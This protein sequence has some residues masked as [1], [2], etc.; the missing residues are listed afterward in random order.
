MKK[1]YA[2][3]VLILLVV[4]TVSGQERLHNKERSMSRGDVTDDLEEL[5]GKPIHVL[6]INKQTFDG[7]NI[8]K[9]YVANYRIYNVNDTAKIQFA[10]KH[11]SKE[12]VDAACTIV[13]VWKNNIGK[14]HKE[15]VGLL[16][17][18]KNAQY[19]AIEI[20]LWI[21]NPTQYGSAI[22]KWEYL[23]NPL[24]EYIDL[25][26]YNSIMESYK[27]SIV[28][29]MAYYGTFVDKVPQESKFEGAFYDQGWKRMILRFNKDSKSYEV[30][31]GHSDSD[32]NNYYKISQF[33]NDFL[34]TS[35]L[36][37]RSLEQY[38]LNFVDSISRMLSNKVWYIFSTPSKCYFYKEK[39]LRSVD[40]GDY[41]W[42]GILL[43]NKRQSKGFQEL[44]KYHLMFSNECD[45]IDFYIEPNTDVKEFLIDAVEYHKEIRDKENQRMQNEIRLRKEREIEEQKYYQK[46]VRLYGGENAKLIMNQQ[47]RIGFTKKM[48][49]ESWGT[50]E[51][52]NSTITQYGKEE[53]WVY[54]I[55]C[56]LYFSGDKLTGIQNVE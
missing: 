9:S 46:L 25:E 2:L 44:Y 52:I 7:Y 10:K 48:C 43:R 53:Q 29:R 37:K 22:T 15:T 56:Y 36:I 19:Y 21:G 11:L 16:L 32:Y 35:D 24:I 30:R 45:T 49:I 6:Y 17:K 47:V 40:K 38:N 51:Y 5:I 34:L 31:C 41:N 14:K 1:L 54:G 3:F 42:C 8:S 28:Y 26:P 33:K 13:K 27:D 50:P 4:G 20:P 55:G 12:R 39:Q 18:N 23:G